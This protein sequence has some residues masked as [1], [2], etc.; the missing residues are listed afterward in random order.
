MVYDRV[1]IIHHKKEF[2]A[3]TTVNGQY[4]KHSTFLQNYLF[5]QRKKAPGAGKGALTLIKVYCPDIQGSGVG[6]F[7]R[8]LFIGLEELE[9]F[10][11]VGAVGAVGVL[12][13][14][15]REIGYGILF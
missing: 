15:L 8:G 6:N 10:F 13:N 9:G 2:T 12:I 3:Q 11:G 7:G 4:Q 1:R 5:A 14:D